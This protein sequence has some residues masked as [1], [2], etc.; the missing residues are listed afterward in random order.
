M[1]P[2]E[3]LPRSLAVTEERPRV[4]TTTAATA[5]SPGSR[6]RTA[7]LTRAVRVA[8]AAK[9]RGDYEA[10]LVHWHPS[11]ELIPPSKGESVVGFDPV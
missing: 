7:M 9:N 2:R 6:L 5:R 8:T 4:P 1:T 11:V 10:I 3:T